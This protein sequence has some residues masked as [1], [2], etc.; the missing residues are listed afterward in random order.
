MGKAFKNIGLGFVVNFIAMQ[1]VTPG[2]SRDIQF[3]IP[4]T[5]EMICHV[6]DS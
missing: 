3:A 5:L 2:S 4:G 6:S 1:D